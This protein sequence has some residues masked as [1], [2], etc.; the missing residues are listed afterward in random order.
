MKQFIRKIFLPFFALM[1]C[2]IAYSTV[3]AAGEG[4]IDSGGGGLGSG[5][6]TDVWYGQDG[7][8]ITVV[9]SEGDIVSIPFD[10]S[11]FDIDSRILHFGKINKL[12]YTAG[13]PLSL[14]SGAYN[15]SNPGI[16]L[17][18]IISK[19]SSWANIEAIR[20][21]FCSEY[22]A[23]LIASRVSIT[24]DNLVSG[25]YKLIIEPIA[26]FTHGSRNYA[27][28]ATEAALYN[29]LSGGTLRSKMPSLTHQNLPLSIFLEIAD[30]GYPAWSGTTSGKVMDSE[31][32][33]ALGIGIVNYK[34]VPKAV[35]EA[36][37]YIY[38]VNTDVIT[39]ITLTSTR[40]VNPKNP[41]SA[42]FQIGGASYRVNNIVIPA[43]GS[44]LVWVKWRTPSDPTTLTINISVSGAATGKTSFTAQIVSLDDNPPPDPLANDTY[45]G[46]SPPS[47]SGNPQNLSAYWSVWSASWKA[48]WRWDPNWRWKRLS[49]SST[50]PK[51][52]TKIHGQWI[53]H[54]EWNDYGSYKFHS[55][56]YYASLSGSMSIMPDDIVPTASGKNM[57]SGYGIW[58]SVSAGFHSNAPGSHYATAQTAVSYF[59]EFKY[60][61][62]WRL[63]T[64]SGG[65]TATFA[66]KP[67][68]FST[69]GRNV[70]FTPVW[71]P[72]SSYTVYTYVIDAWSPTG[73]LSLNLND[74]I[75]IQ[76]SMFDDWYSKRE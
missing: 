35:I 11:N 67:N 56:S 42:T 20:R 7:V 65:M 48:D 57:K 12:Q 18:R 23:Q 3:F 40:E 52:C 28:T 25:N 27:M 63:L 2:F 32:I 4:N 73:M 39:S 55:T 59:P 30:L 10:L 71:Y 54:G 9:T 36:P 53:D 21:Y 70:H 19:S 64:C 29:Q 49:C 37:D 47:I 24:Y 69:Y 62:Y 41:A 16:S 44:Q 14:D 8:R 31:I 6:S 50:C 58:E 68:E 5:T 26:Y 45:P 1:L 75:Q 38:R 33:S 76:G 51:G 34:D 43:N 17:P 15:C 61:N 46:F 74:S 60:K 13:T 72:D 66:F 22:I